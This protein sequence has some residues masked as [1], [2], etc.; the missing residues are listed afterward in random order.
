[1]SSDLDFI[2]GEFSMNASNDFTGGNAEFL[3]KDV[4]GAWNW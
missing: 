2:G 4:A 3:K 1:V